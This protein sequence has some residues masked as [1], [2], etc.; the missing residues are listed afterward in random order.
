MRF[1]EPAIHDVAL[2]APAGGRRLIRQPLAGF[3]MVKAA[4]L[5]R[6]AFLQLRNFAETIS[7]PRS[8]RS[9]E[10]AISGRPATKN[11]LRTWLTA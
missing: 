7:T 6:D 8:R 9:R 3:R 2:P 1:A 11:T 5:L 10:P 4:R